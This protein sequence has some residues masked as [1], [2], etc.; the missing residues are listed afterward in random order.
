MYN[1]TD[2]V[3]EEIAVAPQ[4][5]LMFIG[6]QLQAKY[7]NE[8]ASQARNEPDH[9]RF[10]FISSAFAS[11]ELLPY[12]KLKATFQSEDVRARVAA[13]RYIEQNFDKYAAAAISDL[14]NPNLKPAI[15]TEYLLYGLIAGIDAK[16][17]GALAPGQDR[18]LSTKLPYVPGRERRIVE[19]TGHPNDQVKKQARRLIQR[20]PVDAFR[21]IYA[22]IVSTAAIGKCSVWDQSSE[23][24]QGIIYSSIFFYYNRIVQRTYLPTFADDDVNQL[25]RAAR[26]V[27]ASAVKCLPADLSVDAALVQ[28]GLARFY[29][30]DPQHGHV[31]EAKRAASSFLMLVSGREADYYFD[32]HIDQMKQLSKS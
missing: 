14:Y 23:A 2:S 17:D 19:L 5:N 18:D 21:D 4:H 20:F 12:E 24:S 28:Y 16:S 7:E 6:K 1:H 11:G 30:N 22:N 31:P 9:S 29:Q 32:G 10:S 15:V 13:R 8:D 26:L 27:E 3:L 25:E